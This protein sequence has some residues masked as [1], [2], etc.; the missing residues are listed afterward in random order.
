M[1]ASA[2]RSEINAQN[3]KR[4][5]T[6]WRQYIPFYVMALPGV[7]YMICN[8]YLPMGGIII[9]FKNMNF[10][11]GIWGSDWAGFDNFKF[12]FA[13]QDAWTITRNT[14]LYNS[15]FIVLG[16]VLSIAVAILINEVK[17]KTASKMYQ[18]LILLPFL[19]SWVIVNYLVFA[20]LSAETG[21]LNNSI[22]NALGKPAVS[23][24]NEKQY[25]PYILIISNMWKTIGY[26]MIIYLSSI[27]GISQDYYEAA[28]IDGASKWRQTWAITI[29]L[30]KP[31]IITLFIL[32]VGRIFYSDFG[33][34]YQVP[35]NSGTLYSVTRTIDV[36][37]YNALMRN[38][39][40]GMSSAASVYQS[41]VG[42][43]L[44]LGANL[45]IRKLSRENALF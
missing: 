33:L 31:T 34:F 39:D 3:K 14:L 11:K 18:S 9:A 36:Y 35:R 6:S 5:K 26:S 29:P 21:L 1:E 30:L 32:S 10:K 13:S 15:A 42:F 17:N 38:S 4:R 27:V 44:V 45:L 28:S 24:Y 40:F 37:V 19:M 23:W 2:S 43:T 7:I 25:W 8:N 22:L 20:L 12:L 16:T 41:I